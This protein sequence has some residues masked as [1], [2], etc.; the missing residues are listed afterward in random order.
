MQFKLRNIT[1]ITILFSL[2]VLRS[3]TQNI[4]NKKVLVLHSYHQ[5]FDWTDDISSGLKNV[6]DKELNIEVYYQNLDFRRFFS[7][8]YLEAQIKLQGSIAN[9]KKIDVIVVSDNNAF[10]FIKEKGDKLYPGVPVVFCG[11]TGVDMSI[12]EKHPNYWGI[13]ESID[14]RE[15]L[16]SIKHI[17]PERNHLFIINDKS[18]SGKSIKKELYEVLP[19]F[20]KDFKITYT[21][22]FYKKDIIK[23]A[24]H[25]GDK[26]AIYIL[27]ASKEESG[28]YVCYKPFLNE[29]SKKSQ[30]PIFSSWGIYL[31]YGIIG[32]KLLQGDKQ[33][34][35]VGKLVLKVLKGETA[36]LKQY[37]YLPCV[38]KFDNNLL[39]KF[40]VNKSDLPKGSEVINEISPINKQ[41]IRLAYIIFIMSL[42]ILILWFLAYTRRRRTQ[43]LEKLINEKT[44]DLQ[45]ANEELLELYR[46]KNLFLGIAAHDLRN[47]ISVINGLTD[48]VIK[49]YKEGI[50]DD[51]YQM[52]ITVKNSSEYMLGIVNDFLDI[53]VIESGEMKLSFECTT[54]TSLIDD[55]CEIVQHL[56]KKK[57]ITLK[58]E[59]HYAQ[60]KSVNIDKN[61]YNQ[62]ICNLVGNAIKFSKENSSII[63]RIESDEKQFTTSI[64]DEA[65][66]IAKAELEK[67][68]VAYKQSGAENRQKRGVG[69]GLAICKRIVEAHGGKINVESEEGKGSRFYFTL[70]I[71]CVNC[72]KK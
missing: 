34:E 55:V 61:K 22:I 12:L 54:Y 56:G 33:G 15:T 30:A 71:S 36:E 72:S 66:G 28:E 4:T 39:K 6:L 53:S 24:E 46:E 48:I 59:K 49:D 57:N 17:F 69:L 20:E 26:D 50:P 65:G 35:A 9:N 45:K 19:E 2:L 14:Y 44:K 3:Y 27:I 31:D 8:E 1:I 43:K 13:S 58:V 47:P 42:G 18:I 23:I 5:G 64:I 70:P 29:L 52:A 37:S 63:I 21:D 51:I 62:L 68:F 11:V 60:N 38:Y 41:I 25:L 32:G 40:K 7:E 10:D 67:I 16:Q